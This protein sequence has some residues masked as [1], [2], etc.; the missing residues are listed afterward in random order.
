MFY[1]TNIE[2]KSQ[3]VLSWLK[4][5]TNSCALH[6][7]RALTLTS[8][9]LTPQRWEA[10]NKPVLEPGT[11][12]LEESQTTNGLDCSGALPAIF[13]HRSTALPPGQHV[14][15]AN[16]PPRAVQA[17]PIV[18]S[19]PTVR[20]AFYNLPAEF[21]DTENRE[22][23]FPSAGVNGLGIYMACSENELTELF[24]SKRG[25]GTVL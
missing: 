14:P 13:L 23:P 17:Q 20:A 18:G 21:R 12:G 7:P 2:P 25:D 5:K 24:S 6:P 9:S 22:L 10:L 8:S 3:L 11:Y 19:V 1:I 4:E 15:P 16:D